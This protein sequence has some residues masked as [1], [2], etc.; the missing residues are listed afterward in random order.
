MNRLHDIYIWP[1]N[2]GKSGFP[3]IYLYIRYI[4][5]DRYTLY[6]IQPCLIF[7]DYFQNRLELLCLSVF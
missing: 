6:I 7:F 5:I 4:F 2:A 3:N 1:E